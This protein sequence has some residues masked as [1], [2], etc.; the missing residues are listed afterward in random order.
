MRRGLASTLILAT[1]LLT[2]ACGG[3]P[4][5]VRGSEA[6]E[7]DNYA[8]STGLDKRDLE[9]LFDENAKSLMESGAMRRWKDASRDGKEPTVAIFP[10][11]NETS[12]HIDSQLQA[13]LSKFET[14][15]VNSGYVTVIS[16][17]RQEQLIRELRLQQSAAFDPDKA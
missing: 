5:Y 14:Q 8:M 10:V 13:L 2:T 11:K 6:P 12:E 9:K 4:A 7:L 16:R 17:E 15:L 1:G 3:G